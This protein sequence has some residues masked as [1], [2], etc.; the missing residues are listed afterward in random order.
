[1]TAVLAE[2]PVA[3]A[4]NT[5]VALLIRNL[6]DRPSPPGTDAEQRERARP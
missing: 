1:M 2:R 5:A 4:V 6:F 3:L